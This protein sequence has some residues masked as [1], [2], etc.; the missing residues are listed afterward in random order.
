[1]STKPDENQI[2][3]ATAAPAYR[4]PTPTDQDIDARHRR[5]DES[6]RRLF[7]EIPETAPATARSQWTRRRGRYPPL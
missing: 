5:E 1:M 6:P 4:R 3:D 2:P 7:D